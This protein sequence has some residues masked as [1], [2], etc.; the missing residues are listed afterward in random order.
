MLRVS[1][2]LAAILSLWICLAGTSR[3]AT[4]LFSQCLYKKPQ[5]ATQQ[6]RPTGRGKQAHPDHSLTFF[7]LP[8]PFLKFCQLCWRCCVSASRRAKRCL[9]LWLFCSFFF[10]ALVFSSSVSLISSHCSK[11]ALRGLRGSCHPPAAATV[12]ATCALCSACVQ[13]SAAGASLV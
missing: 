4:M 12:Q 7:W 9:L 3:E 8:L 6:Q 13:C 2:A 11:L 1:W 5:H 10:L